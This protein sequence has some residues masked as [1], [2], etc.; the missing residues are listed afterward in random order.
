MWDFFLSFLGINLQG[1]LSSRQQAATSV[2]KDV[3]FHGD[4]KIA[5]ISSSFTECAHR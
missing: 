3:G 1:A 4:G 5:F 2:A